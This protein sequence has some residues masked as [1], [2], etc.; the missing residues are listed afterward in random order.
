MGDDLI[1]HEVIMKVDNEHLVQVDSIIEKKKLTTETERKIVELENIWDFVYIGIDAGSGTLGVSVLDHLLELPETMHK[2]I[3]INNRERLLDRDGNS[4]KK[5]LK[6]DLYDNLRA[7]MERGFILLLD[8]DEVKESLKSIQFE[9]VIEHNMVSDVRIF[10]HDSHVVEGLIRAAW[11]AHT[12]KT[13]D[14]WAR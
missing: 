12:D 10:G 14:L 5:I 11:L 2:V 3:D 7:L 4:K 1:T 8:D 6:E 13:L 9:P